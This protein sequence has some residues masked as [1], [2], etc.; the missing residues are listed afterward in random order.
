MFTPK[1]KLADIIFQNYHLLKVLDRFE[2]KLGFGDKTVEQVCTDYKINSSFFLE[3]INSYHDENYFPEKKL[4]N[5][6][7]KLIIDYLKKSHYY[8]NECEIP[9]I[10]QMIDELIKQEQQSP[11]NIKLLK[12]FFNEYRREV[13]NHT[14]TEDFEVFPYVLMVEDAFFNENFRNSDFYQKFNTYSI[15]DY[16]IEHSDIEGKLRDLKSIM[17]K[18]LPPL[19]NQKA[20]LDILFALYEL[21]KDLNDHSRIEDT[22]LVPKVRAMENAIHATKV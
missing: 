20:C 19:E 12:R 7:L 16:A 8:Y 9:R 10:E 5:F 15:G 3:I 13:K 22:V 21:E 18:Y 6:S 17:I 4:Q 1:H 11:D 14:D 2:I